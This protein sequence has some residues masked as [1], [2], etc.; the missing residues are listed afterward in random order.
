MKKLIITILFSSM[1]ALSAC[2]DGDENSLTS[3]S[4]SGKG[5][6]SFL[7]NGEVFRPQASSNILFAQQSHR[8]IQLVTEYDSSKNKANDFFNIEI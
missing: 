5:T 6:I 3:P 4:T 1:I 8:M 7:L 2:G